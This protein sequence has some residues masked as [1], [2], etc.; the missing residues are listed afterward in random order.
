MEATA[1]YCISDLHVDYAENVDWVRQVIVPHDRDEAKSSILIVAGDVTDKLDLLRETLKALRNRFGKVLYCNGN[2]ELWVKEADTQRGCLDSMQKFKEIMTMC[3]EIDVET[4]PITVISKCGQERLSIVPLFSWYDGSLYL[5]NP[6]RNDDL[7]IWTDFWLCKWPNETKQTLTS[8]GPANNPLNEKPEVN[9]TKYFIDRNEQHV[10]N[11]VAMEE[12]MSDVNEVSKERHTVIS[13][14][15]F[16][17]GRDLFVAY[18]ESLKAAYEK[19]KQ[20]KPSSN[21]IPT[22]SSSGKPT[23]PNFSTVAGTQLLHE[24]I[25]RLGS[26]V[27]VFGHSHRRFDQVL[28]GVRYVNNPIG[29]PHE[30]SKGI[31]TGPYLLKIWSSQR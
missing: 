25:T 10:R 26:K 23:I 22:V 15:H 19:Y 31:L 3:E 5:H 18:V 14:S 16:L 8:I 9:V 21:T 12:A 28:D 24:Q 29:Y 17:P 30:R 11:I 2:H 7:G 6:D 27:H 1:V 4:K 13:F 20:N